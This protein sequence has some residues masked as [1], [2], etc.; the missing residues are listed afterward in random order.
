MVFK[1]LPN[2]EGKNF[3][4]IFNQ[5]NPF[6][7]DLLKKLLTFNPNKRI[8]VKEALNHPYLQAVQSDED[9]AFFFF[10]REI[11]IS[12]QYSLSK[13]KIICLNLSLKIILCRYN[14]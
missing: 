14:S 8:T 6:A 13:L 2:K 10:L 12:L 4:E 3:E 7:I 5:T 9:E 11:N 1:N